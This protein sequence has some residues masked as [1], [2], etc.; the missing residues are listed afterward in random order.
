MTSERIA[1]KAKEIVLAMQE[2]LGEIWT[3]DQ[4][5]TAEHTVIVRLTGADVDGAIRIDLPALRAALAT[6][7]THYALIKMAMKAKSPCVQ[8][9]A[10]V[11]VVRGLDAII[12]DDWRPQ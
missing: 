2:N 3:E 1:E 12:E 6:I 11:D 5:N 10:L 7:K 8:E 4:R 9:L